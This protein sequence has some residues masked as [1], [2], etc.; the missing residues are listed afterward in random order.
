MEVAQLI[1]RI[2]DDQSKEED[3]LIEMYHNQLKKIYYKTCLTQIDN[4]YWYM[5]TEYDDVDRNDYSDDEEYDEAKEYWTWKPKNIFVAIKHLK[6]ISSW[7]LNPA[8]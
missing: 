6:R 3:K 1:E 5:N 8:I 7:L 4:L 2:L